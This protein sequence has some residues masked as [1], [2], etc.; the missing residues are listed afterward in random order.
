MLTALHRFVRQVG[1]FIAFFS[2][3]LG[4]FILSWTLLPIAL[5]PLRDRAAR[6]HRAR[7]LVSRGFRLFT[8]YLRTFR[9]MTVDPSVE[10]LALPDGPCVV[11][12][13]HPTLIDVTA[14]LSIQPQTVVIV[15]PSLF[16]NPLVGPLLRLCDHIPG[17]KGHSSAVLEGAIDRLRRGMSVMLFPEGTRSPPGAL[18][19]LKRGAFEIASRAVVPVVPLLIRVDPPVL[20]H[21]RKWHQVPLRVVSYSMSRLPDLDCGSWDGDTKAMARD[22]EATYRKHLA[23]WRDRVLATEDVDPLWNLSST[24]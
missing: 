9:F 21:Y 5:L 12:A 22:V 8:W 24:S 16:N 14:L 19:P 23:T 18:H 7:W 3:G 1:V 17:G 15:K 4:G 10:E 13:N 11:V 6:S 2:F 20:N